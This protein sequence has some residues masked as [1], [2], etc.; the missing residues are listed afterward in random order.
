MVEKEQFICFNQHLIQTNP[1]TASLTLM[2]SMFLSLGPDEFGQE[3]KCC[4]DICGCKIKGV[5]TVPPRCEIL[6]GPCFGGKN[7]ENGQYGWVLEVG[8][9][10]AEARQ[11]PRTKN[12]Q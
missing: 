12:H 2:L 11:D 10:H 7:L 1:S 6:S 3:L 4:D 8:G 9:G 5:I